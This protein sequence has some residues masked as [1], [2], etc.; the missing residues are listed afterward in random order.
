MTSSRAE[1]SFATALNR[2]ELFASIALRDEPPKALHPDEEVLL[3]LPGVASDTPKVLIATAQ[4]LLLMH[5]GG[6]INRAQVKREVPAAQVAGVEY[7]P[8]AFTKI[9]VDIAGA[10]RIS[11]LPNKRVDAERFAHGMNH[12]IR[13]GSLPS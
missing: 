7:K 5:V 2:N 10:R 4:R 9:H 6:V 12:L 11:M 3:V 8:G 1:M 13:T